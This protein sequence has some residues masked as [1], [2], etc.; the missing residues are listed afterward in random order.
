MSLARAPG[1][2]TVSAAHLIRRASELMAMNQPALAAGY[3]E[4][5]LLREPANVN[6]LF[7]LGRLEAN[8]GNHA[9]AASY[10]KRILGLRK[11]EGVAGGNLL[12]SHGAD[13]LGILCQDGVPDRCE[14]SINPF[15][16]NKHEFSPF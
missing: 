15:S 6:I 14:H 5:A 10:G 4:G 11:P 2:N 1:P 8:R 3:L 13:G 7:D 16:N 12:L 9:K